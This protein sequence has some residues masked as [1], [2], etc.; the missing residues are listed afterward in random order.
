MRSWTLRR[1]G[2]ATG[3]KSQWHPLEDTGA[4]P[5]TSIPCSAEAPLALGSLGREGM[6]GQLLVQLSEHR[7]VPTQPGHLAGTPLRPAQ[8]SQQA[9]CRRER[10]QQAEA[11]SQGAPSGLRHPAPRLRAVFS[12]RSAPAP[13]LRRPYLGRRPGRQRRAQAPSAGR[14]PPGLGGRPLR[15][16]AQQRLA[17]PGGNGVA[18]TQRGLLVCREHSPQPAGKPPG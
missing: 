13:R 5:T 6:D 16:G 12:R 4:V 2:G 17:Q 14:W 3:V 8:R 9:P 15:R 11:G 7:D 1:E 18:G 10:S